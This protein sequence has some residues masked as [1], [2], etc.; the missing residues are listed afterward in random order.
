MPGYAGSEADLGY[1]VSAIS[2]Q[3]LEE[4]DKQI[5]KFKYNSYLLYG[6]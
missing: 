5:K 6:H 4:N 3:L 1:Q 2:I